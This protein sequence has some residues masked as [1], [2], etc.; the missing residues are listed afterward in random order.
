MHNS[1]ILILNIF[2][3]S[4]KI[5]HL[6][7]RNEKKNIE[8]NLSANSMCDSCRDVIEVSK[9]NKSKTLDVNWIDGWLLHKKFPRI[10]VKPNQTVK[11]IK[12]SPN[13]ND[14]K[15]KLKRTVEKG[16]CPTESN[17]SN[18]QLRIC[19]KLIVFH[20]EHRESITIN[21][22]QQRFVHVWWLWRAN[23]L[24]WA[25]TLEMHTPR[26]IRPTNEKL[27]K[28]KR[29]SKQTAIYF[30]LFCWLVFGCRWWL[31][32]FVVVCVAIRVIVLLSIH[33][34]AF[35]SENHQSN[36]QFTQHA[37]PQAEERTPISNQLHQFDC[38]D[39]FFLMVCSRFVCHWKQFESIQ[40]ANC[41]R[42]SIFGPFPQKHTQTPCPFTL[43][44]AAVGRFH[45]I[46]RL[47]FGSE[48]L[49]VFCE[50][51]IRL[52][53]WIS[54]FLVLMAFSCFAFHWSWQRK[55]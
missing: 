21:A 45:F 15:N 55:Y 53:R 16:E 38:F 44:R 25:H 52:F 7:K 3:N 39:F 13:E 36:L 28:N 29:L 46:L 30:R 4:I 17:Q 51:W 8:N 22:K 23:R 42:I 34:Y 11:T 14:E 50:W 54:L 2:V 5:G 20:F 48:L 1:V 12:T 19:A 9:R 37:R 27:K 31:S 10:Q 32:M 18:G 47:V 35:E 6:H 26:H 43:W 24:R 40:L 33:S 49:D 41:T